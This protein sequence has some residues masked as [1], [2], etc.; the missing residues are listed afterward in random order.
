[1]DFIIRSAFGALVLFLAATSLWAHHSFSAVY[2]VSK[3]LTLTGTLTKIDWRNPHAEATIETKDDRG[4][5]EAWVIETMPPSW[6]R[7]RNV[8]KSDF[9]KA[10]GQTVTVEVVQAKDGSLSGL[11]QQIT[12]PDGKS[13]RLPE[14]MPASP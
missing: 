12:F 10:I 14:V 8:S 1:M 7:T 4:H 9:E 3:T 2:D 13:L 11:L 5:V 6:L